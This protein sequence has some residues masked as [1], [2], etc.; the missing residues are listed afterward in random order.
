M[1]RGIPRIARRLVAQPE[2]QGEGRPHLPIV[3][4]IHG[5]IGFAWIVRG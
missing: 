4:D 1:P 2:V 5:E 3:L